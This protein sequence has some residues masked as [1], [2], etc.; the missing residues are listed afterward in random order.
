MVGYFGIALAQVLPDKPYKET[1]LTYLEPVISTF[2][3]RQRWNLFA[4]DLV[5]V[6]QYSTVLLTYE[7]GSIRLY[8]WPRLDKLGVVE[9]FS[10]QRIRRFVTEFWARPRYKA[11]WPVSSRHLEKAFS[12]PDNAVTRV[13][14]GFNFNKV[15]DFE[16][17]T[18]RDQLSNA[19]FRDTTFI[20]R[21]ED[22][23]GSR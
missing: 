21:V 14:F 16:H 12:L 20:Y 19:Y 7:D 15:P 10:H 2:G 13:E 9:K 8:E 5:R 4:P 17:F 6:N 11:F 23:G 3:L 22:K 18:R 1:I